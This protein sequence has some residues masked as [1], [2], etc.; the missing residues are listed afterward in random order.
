MAEPLI[1]GGVGF[2]GA[3]TALLLPR[4]G[5]EEGLENAAVWRL[6]DRRG[7]RGFCPTENLCREM[8]VP[9]GFILIGNEFR[10]DATSEILA[11]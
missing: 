11:I 2:V 8:A 1:D 7:L 3:V 6:T 4:G 9:C 5:K 10:R